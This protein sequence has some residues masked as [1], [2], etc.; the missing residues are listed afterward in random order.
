[1]GADLKQ[2]GSNPMKS[3]TIPE[4]LIRRQGLPVSCVNRVGWCV[5]IAGHARSFWGSGWFRMEWKRRRAGCAVGPGHFYRWGCGLGQLKNGVAED[6]EY[7]SVL[8]GSSWRQ[9]IMQRENRTLSEES[10]RRHRR[11]E[12]RCPMNAD[13]IRPSIYLKYLQHLLL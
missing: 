5:E 4:A 7:V 2:K 3:Q 8:G 1:M 6:L 10:D 9:R 11:L 12:P 13:V